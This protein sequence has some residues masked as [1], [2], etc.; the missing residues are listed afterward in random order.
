MVLQ[1]AGESLEGKQQ[2]AGAVPAKHQPGLDKDPLVSGG[3]GDEFFQATYHLA[4][5]LCQFPYLLQGFCVS[6]K[7]LREFFSQLL[8][9][10]AHGGAAIHA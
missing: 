8:R 3:E 10:V 2:H 6:G 5:P 1:A 7:Q 9:Q 4:E